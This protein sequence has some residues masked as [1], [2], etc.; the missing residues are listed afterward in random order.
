MGGKVDLERFVACA[1]WIVLYITIRQ[2]VSNIVFKFYIVQCVFMTIIMIF[3]AVI[4]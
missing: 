1:I 3:F 4:F 2:M